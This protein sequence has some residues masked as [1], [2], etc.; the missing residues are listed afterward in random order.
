MRTSFPI[1]FYFTRASDSGE[2]VRRATAR[3]RDPTPLGT[4]DR[5]TRPLCRRTRFLLRPG[6]RPPRYTRYV[7]ILTRRET[8][9]FTYSPRGC[10]CT[11][12]TTVFARDFTIISHVLIIVCVYMK[13]ARHN[14]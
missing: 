1:F 11:E 7:F 5:C 10:V 8:P 14:G 9:R 12:G 3:L 6:R 13:Q 2:F 4:D